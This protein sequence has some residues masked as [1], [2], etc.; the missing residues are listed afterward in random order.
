M[1]LTFSKN[2]QIYGYN[3]SLSGEYICVTYTKLVTIIHDRDINSLNKFSSF[4]I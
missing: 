4:S 3:W 2:S 1:I